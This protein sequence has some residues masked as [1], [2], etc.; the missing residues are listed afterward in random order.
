MKNVWIMILL[1]PL[2]SFAND[3][4]IHLDK[5]KYLLE[6]VKQEEGEG[7]FERITLVR[8]VNSPKKIDMGFFY[9]F[10]RLE[11]TQWEER[12]IWIPPRYERVCHAT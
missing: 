3:R 1:M 12:R 8:D 6:N 11:C 4:E 5:R 7:V 2:V 9:K 10:R